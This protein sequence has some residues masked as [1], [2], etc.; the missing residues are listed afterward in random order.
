L[1]SLGDGVADAKMMNMLDVGGNIGLITIGAFKKHPTQMRIVAVE[2]SPSTYFLLR[3]NLELNQIPVLSVEDFK[4][5]PNKPGV[6]A[7]NSGV[8]TVDGQTF[9][10]CYTPP[11]TQNAEV[12]ECS[13]EDAARKPQMGVQQCLN[14]MTFALPSY[15]SFFEGQ[16]L[17]MI[18]MDCEGCE[19]SLLPSLVKV[20]GQQIDR[21]S[22]ELHAVGNE[23]EDIACKYEEGHWFIHVC[24]RQGKYDVVPL[25]E[26]CSQGP[27][28]PSCVN[29]DKN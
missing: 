21:F 17:S 11:Q 15:L 29:P 8:G 4:N 16:P 23:F 1:T 2:P 25:K 19:K 14:I 3:W 9:G 10:L 24:F 28:R 20:Q 27:T 26:R 5:S 13:A 18:K 7:L 6:L 12:C 22:G